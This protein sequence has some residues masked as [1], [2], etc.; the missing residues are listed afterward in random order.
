M[1]LFFVNLQFL[2][3]NN[4]VTE[5]TSIEY[6]DLVENI[7]NATEYTGYIGRDKYIVFDNSSVER[8]EKFIKGSLI[9]FKKPPPYEDLRTGN[10]TTEP[11]DYEV[12]YSKRI[13]FYFY[14]KKHI[15][16][17]QKKTNELDKASNIEKRINI[18]F[19]ERFNQIKEN[20]NKFLKYRLSINLI[21]KKEDLEKVI[22]R[23]NVKSIDIEVTY[24]NSDELED[25]IENELKQ[26]KTHKVCHSE[27]AHDDSIMNGV[28]EYAKKLS[29]IALR[30]GNVIMR[31]V[32]DDNKVKKYIM[33]NKIVERDIS[34]KYKDKNLFVDEYIEDEIIS[35]LNEARD[36]NY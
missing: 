20:D 24:P 1:K 12:Q 10:I 33:K 36:E 2:P 30:L 26:V 13:K 23:M 5:L 18:L 25:N 17:I 8:N 29:H 27:K 32:D 14:S 16:V 21:S 28:T 6:L 11:K 3:I 9:I 34:E 7:I 31:Y 35:V 22:N 4:S 15:L 19:E